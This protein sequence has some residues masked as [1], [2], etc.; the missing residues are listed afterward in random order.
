MQIASPLYNKAS[1]TTEL[2]AE[3]WSLVDEK[4]RLFIIFFNDRLK[5]TPLNLY[6]FPSVLKGI[7]HDP[8]IANEP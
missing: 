6:H 3:L 5:S 4:Y 7:E 1:L 2:G 8:K